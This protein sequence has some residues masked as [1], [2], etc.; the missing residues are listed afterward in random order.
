[1]NTMKVYHYEGAGNSFVLLP[2]FEEVYSLQELPELARRL[3][4][5]EGFGTDGL[6]LL[7]K[8]EQGGDCKMLFYNNDGSTAEMCGNGARCLCR[9][10][11]DHG[12]SGDTQAIET[13][14]G[15]VTGERLGENS[16]R[17][18]LNTPSVFRQ[19]ETY[20]YVELGEPGIP[21]AVVEADLSRNRDELREFARALRHSPEFPR[22]ANVNLYELTG[23]NSLK[24]LTFERGVEDF[25]LACGTGTGATVY[26]LYRS[27]RVSGKNTHV[28]TDGGELAVD[29]EK[30]YALSVLSAKELGED[31]YLTGPAEE[32]RQ[33]EWNN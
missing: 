33:G 12:L 7:R 1:M 6:M 26:T 32:I 3:C 4:G 19:A 22:G 5:K 21:H 8:P 25:T 16:Y 27:G 28:H 18:R 14:A 17:I 23:E 9:F 11:H 30:V 24:L 31:I 2:D 13:P 15:M 20:A 29:I 10:C